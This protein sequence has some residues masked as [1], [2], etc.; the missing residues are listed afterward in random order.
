[1][2]FNAGFSK[3]LMFYYK[4]GILDGCKFCA[5]IFAIFLLILKSSFDVVLNRGRANR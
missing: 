3:S 2:V 5:H 1:M 4:L